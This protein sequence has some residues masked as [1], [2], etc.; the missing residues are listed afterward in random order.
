MSWGTFCKMPILLFN[1]DS[2]WN[3]GEQTSEVNGV[4]SSYIYYL[5]SL[6]LSNAIKVQFS[7]REGS[8]ALQLFVNYS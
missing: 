7:A 3:H 2:A 1:W 8:A 4:E 6:V 5:P